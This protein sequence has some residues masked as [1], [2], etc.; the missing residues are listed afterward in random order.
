[1]ETVPMWAL[2]L[3]G[4]FGVQIV[5]IVLNVLRQVL[6][7]RDK[8]IPPEVFHVLPIIGSAISYGNDPINFFFQCREKYGEVFTFVLLGRKVT[9]ALGPK[10]NDLILGGKPTVVSAEEAY[11]HLTTPVFGKH[12]V[13]DCPNETLMQQKKF[14]KFGLNTDNFRAYMGMIEEETEQFI[15]GDATFAPYH[16]AS[17]PWG[18]FNSFKSMSELTILTASRTLQGAEV[19]SRLDKTFAQRYNDLDGGFTPINFLFPS[20]PLPS[21][22]R[23]DKAQRAMSQFYQEII[24]ARRAGSIEHEH[25]MLAALETQKYRDGRVLSDVEKAHIMI[26]LLMAG[27]HTSSATSSWTLLHIADRPDV[28]QA[29]YDEQVKFFRGKDGK[30]RTME[31][32]DLKDLPLLDAVIRE[33]LRIHPPI[34]SIMR[35]VLQDLPVPQ[36]LAAPSESGSYVIPKG[37]YVLASPSVAGMDPNVWPNPN[38]WDPYRWISTDGVSHGAK[39]ALK[40]EASGEK[41]DYG[42]GMISKGT[43]SPYQPFGAGRHRCIGESFA[44]VQLGSIVATLVRNLE[45]RLNGPFPQHNYHTMIVVPKTPCDV[46]FR[47]RETA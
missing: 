5:A 22:Y 35:K 2:L 26:A 28:Q 12:V 32:E 43:E 14:V 23:R 7:P 17:R 4:F 30:F 11:T 20:L 27:Q 24:Q 9:V 36:S 39:L 31:Y 46:E 21:Y 16:Q 25:D 1:M 3:G 44:Y 41:V 18:R 33:T 37:H 47:R 8:N 40:D 42:F 34:H 19:R 45:L 6:L 13:Y 10:G 15:K 29:L 38:E